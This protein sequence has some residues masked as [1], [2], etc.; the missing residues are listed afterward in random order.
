MTCSLTDDVVYERAED[1]VLPPHHRCRGQIGLSIGLNIGSC[2]SGLS[3]W[4]I[5]LTLLHLRVQAVH[6]GVCSPGTSWQAAS[7]PIKS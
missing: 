3:L 2:V 6:L 7:A 5:L 4:L 1:Q